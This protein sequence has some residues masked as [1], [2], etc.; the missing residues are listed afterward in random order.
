MKSMCVYVHG[1]KLWNDLPDAIKQ[2]NNANQFQKS[3]LSFFV[4][5]SFVWVLFS[6]FVLLGLLCLYYSNGA[7]SK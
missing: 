6:S 4:V 5:V 1:V 3:K 2:S 7:R